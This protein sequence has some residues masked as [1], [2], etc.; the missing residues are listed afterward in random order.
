MTVMGGILDARLLMA[1]AGKCPDCGEALCLKQRGNEN[2]HA[3]C[4]NYEEAVKSY[5]GE[6][7]HE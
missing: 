7:K 4:P 6:E 5:L 3:N 2:V 1:G